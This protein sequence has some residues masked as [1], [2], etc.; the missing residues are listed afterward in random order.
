MTMRELSSSSK[1]KKEIS[2]LL[3]E[4]IIE[5]Y[6]EHDD[7]HLVIA[8]GYNDIECENQ[9]THSHEE[10]DTLILNQVIVASQRKPHSGIHVY[11]P[12]TDVLILLMHLVAKG[13]LDILLS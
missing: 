9:I 7:F 12:D 6:S 13:Y 4:A 11:S 2:K 1:T 5:K 8:F 10:A 3:C